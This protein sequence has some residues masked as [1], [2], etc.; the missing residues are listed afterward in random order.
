MNAGLVHRALFVATTV[1]LNLTPAPSHAIDLR[2][3]GEA[4]LSVDVKAAGTALQISGAL[5][6]ELGAPLAL[7]D[8]SIEVVRETG[9]PVDVGERVLTTTI[10][11][12][13]SAQFEL[14][15]GAY[16]VRL[17][18]TSDL[19]D[20]DSVTARVVLERLTPKLELRAPDLTHGRESPAQLKLRASANGIGVRAPAEVYVNGE[21]VGSV[22]LDARGRGVYDLREHLA[23]GPNEV[24]GLLR[25][26]RMRP[27]ARD[28]TSAHFV[29]RA[30][31]E[32]E[33]SESRLRLERGLVVSARVMDGDAPVPQATVSAALYNEEP[34]A[35]GGAVR[36][37]TGVTR[38]DGRA[39]LFFSTADLTEGRW[40]AKVRFLPDA[41]ERIEADTGVVAI[42]RTSS[43]WLLNVL[44]LVTVM[45][46]AAALAWRLSMTDWRA[47]W[48]R[49]RDDD[50]QLEL[51]YEATERVELT[52]LTP[53]GDAPTGFDA[54]GGF[55]WDNWKAAPVPFATITLSPTAGGEPI[56]AR[57]GSDGAFAVRGIPKGA[58]T[59]TA[60]AP[61]F[62]DGVMTLSIPH[63]GKLRACRVGL[64][65]IPLKVRRF[66]QAWVARTRGKDL[67]GTLSPRQIED[68]IWDE[69]AS[70]QIAALPAERVDAARG[71]LQRM[72]A[73]RA[74]LG[75][76]DFDAL[77]TS[78]TDLVEESYF[79]GR[80][81]DD[82]LWE[83]AVGIVRRLDRQLGI[84]PEQEGA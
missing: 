57:A 40:S 24:G 64:V 17:R 21:F 12:K 36:R 25:A 41:G 39:E 49:R 8:V 11:G 44:G 69:V 23:P 28:V 50:E 7:R 53:G 35:P 70:R 78:V 33:L 51:S 31:L 2:V 76:L 48:R 32:A 26:T 66:Y 9:E 65:A 68:A 82:A 1:A 52:T 60:R 77:L 16:M 14:D 30:T 3:R 42:D 22:E 84:E 83:L 63:D 79:S 37:E 74:E 80:L 59:L 61:G 45:A 46:G 67:W 10:Q 19:L 27:E 18:H 58:Y 81:Y 20:A 13:L 29:G 73:E 75:A 4:R 6:D 38:A 43:R 72:L 15:P 62:A 34:G 56:E 54:I 47:L 5:R 71:R 55:V